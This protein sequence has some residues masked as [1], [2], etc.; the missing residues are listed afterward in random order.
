MKKGL[1]IIAGMSLTASLSLQAQLTNRTSQVVERGPHH[2]TV[3]FIESYTNRTSGPISKTNR[4]TTLRAGMHR[5]VNGAWVESAP[6]IKPVT[7]GAKA[8]GGPHEVFFKN[9]VASP[10]AVQITLSDGRR[11]SGHVLGLYYFDAESG[12]SVRLATIKSSVGEILPDNDVV[13]RDCFDGLVGD[14]KYR[15]E[16]GRLEQDIVIRANPVPPSA[17]GLSDKMTRLEVI[18]EWIEGQPTARRERI[19][20]RLAEGAARQTMAEPDWTDEWIDFGAMQMVNGRAFR[21][22]QQTANADQKSH[23][24]GKRWVEIGG[25]RLLVESVEYEMIEKELSAMNFIPA[26][27]GGVKLQASQQRLLPNPLL[28]PLDEGMLMAA[29]AYDADGL[30]I[31]YILVTS[32]PS[33][34]LGNLDTYLVEGWVTVSQSLTIYDGAV[35][36]YAPGAKITVSGYLTT[37][38]SGL[39]I[40]TARD[41]DTVGVPLPTST[42]QISGMYGYPALEL[43]NVYGTT[44]RNLQFRHSMIALSDYSGYYNYHYVQN[45]QFLDCYRGINSYYTPV[46]CSY[47]TMCSVY[48]PYVD[49]GVLDG[50]YSS[51][52]LQHSYTTTLSGCSGGVAFPACDPPGNVYNGAQLVTITSS[53]PDVTIRYRLVPAYD[54]IYEVTENDPVIQPGQQVQVDGAKALIMK[55][56]KNGIPQFA[57][58]KSI[59]SY[60][61][62][63]E[64]PGGTQGASLAGPWFMPINAGDYLLDFANFD[65]IVDG[66]LFPHHQ[67]ADPYGPGVQA[68]TY[69]NFNRLPAGPH[70]IQIKVTFPNSDIIGESTEYVELATQVGNFVSTDKVTFHQWNDTIQGASH[71]VRAKLAHPVANWT[72]RIFSHTGQLLRT[73]TGSTSN[74]EVVYEWDLRDSSGQLRTD[75]NQD[76]SFSATLDVDQAARAAMGGGLFWPIPTPLFFLNF[77]PVGNWLFAYQDFGKQIPP[78]Q[79]PTVQSFNQENAEVM[80]G[81]VIS[82]YQST[83]PHNTLPPPVFPLVKL[84]FAEFWEPEAERTGIISHFDRLQDWG[85]LSNY[86]KNGKIRNLYY[87]GHGSERSIGGD[88]ESRYWTNYPPPSHWVYQVH[89][90]RLTHDKA[91][92]DR[93]DLIRLLRHAPV[94]DY[95]FVFLDGCSTGSGGLCEV[96][97]I[98][99]D[100][101][102]T[103]SEFRA[104]HGNVRLRAFAGWK[105]DVAT[106]DTSSQ[107]YL[108]INPNTGA[109]S[110]LATRAD[111]IANWA[112]FHRPALVN[113]MRDAV[114][115]SGWYFGTEE[116]LLRKDD[117]PGPKGLL[118]VRGYRD[119]RIDEDNQ[120]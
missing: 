46:Y 2:Q 34:S 11:M 100:E 33:L 97:G 91:Y 5:Q 102:M 8:S 83:P 23:Q 64:L 51:P 4:V 42:G 40:F 57:S 66:A 62:K 85:V 79:I 26:Q 72:L 89:K 18:T 65:L 93:K 39:A 32:M 20:K 36:K 114:M 13:Y 3:E 90:M 68:G 108:N 27:P 43:Y 113:A 92:L 70:T 44:I 35:V 111:F 55:A 86:L 50:S 88:Y 103:L 101:Q 80:M 98:P 105:R 7:G 6:E 17:F 117:S 56:W 63:I 22:R 99:R 15:Y 75:L 84:R 21:T 109:Q 48:E 41:D 107:A 53:T 52:L 81:G 118:A 116:F 115:N 119:L 28:E 30:V 106:A 1:S 82:F 96:F 47:L 94:V 120:Y 9:D 59:H 104:K 87:I 25:R 31:D 77:P 110:F 19:I 38:S 95:R 37:P 14:L 60:L 71:T 45:C 61:T 112:H 29:K 49:Q 58:L 67:V 54:S 73:A 24:V 10:A 78:I 16:P 69:I 12:Q 74:G 76:P